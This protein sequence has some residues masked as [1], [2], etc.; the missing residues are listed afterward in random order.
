MLF[1]NPKSSKNLKIFYV[2]AVILNTI[3]VMMTAVRGSILAIGVGF[4]IFALLYSS[5]YRS[6]RAKNILLGFIGLIFV[7]IVLGLLLK[8]TSFVQNSGYLKR[9]TAFNLTDYTV[10]T[11]FWAWQAGIEGWKE[12][13]KTIALGWGP[14]NFDVPFSKH[15]NPKFFRGPGSETLFDRAHNMFVEILVTMGLLGFLS[16]L[17]IFFFSLMVLWKKLDSKDDI[18]YAIGLISLIFAYAIHNSFIFDTSANFFVFF[19]ILGFISFISN[20]KDLRDKEIKPRPT[21]VNNGLFSIVAGILFILI[22]VGIYKI[23]VIPSIANYTTTR[24]I[25]AG[26]NNDF[27]GAVAKY[28]EALEY[29]VPGKYEIRHR[30]AQYILEQSSS[31]KLKPEQVDAVNAAI[32]AVQKNVDENK[33]DYLPYLYLSRLYIILGKDDPKSPYNDKALEYSMAALKIAP[34]FVRTYYEIGQGYLNKDDLASAAIYFKK[35]AELN[36]DVGL[37]YW[38]WGIVEIE[39][40]NTQLGLSIIEDVIKSGKYTP[41]ESDMTKL[42]NIYAKTNDI[43]RLIWAH[44]VLVAIKPDNAQYHA[45]F[46][47][48]YARAGKIDDAVREAKKAVELDPNFESEARSFIQ[49]LGRQW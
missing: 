9:I 19:T 24:A 3:A 8:N 10:Q 15:F 12:S 27:N 2:S 1:F 20:P 23:N 25:I 42:I 6:K 5:A 33:P 26:W 32:E 36:P 35:A 49:S 45:S 29:N 44:S 43:P 28:K 18:L 14:E 22:T 31:G 37:S 30:F 40:G 39:K 34:D 46:A 17:S 38:Y 47:V 13:F 48:A 11:R 41:S 16:Y 21:K 4:L 7:F